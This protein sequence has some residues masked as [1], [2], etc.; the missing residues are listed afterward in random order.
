MKAIDELL[1]IEMKDLADEARHNWGKKG[2]TDIFDI[3]DN[4]S[5]FV[6]IPLNTTNISAFTTYMDEEFVVVIN[7]NGTL[8]RERFSGAHEL[9]HLTYEKDELKKQ[10]K[11]TRDPESENKANIFAT[12]F[13]MPEDG[14]KTIF[15]KLVN[16]NPN[17][18]QPRHIVRMQQKFKVSYRA[19]LKRLIQLGLCDKTKYEDLREYS[20]LE[21]ADELKKITKEEGFGLELITSSMKKSISQENIEIARRL[22]EDGKIS[23]GKLDYLLSFIDKTPEDYGYYVND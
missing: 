20:T 16:Q 4:A 3:L 14:I 5:L 8:G 12:E 21:K 22:Y 1:R 17:E 23:Y 6:R 18:I 19:M 10:N 2:I 15:Y 9:Y 11:L 13:L 7:S